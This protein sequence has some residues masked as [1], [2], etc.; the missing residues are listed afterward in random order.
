MMPNRS[1]AATII[2]KE[3]LSPFLAELKANRITKEYWNECNASRS[4]FSSSELEVMKK[5]CNNR[6]MK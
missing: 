3:K 6:E 5:K 2:S 1:N 4:L